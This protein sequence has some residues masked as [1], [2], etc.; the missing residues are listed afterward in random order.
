M[1]AT[2]L[3]TVVCSGTLSHFSVVTLSP[4][5]N[6]LPSAT[7][8]QHNVVLLTPR[9]SGGVVGLATVLQQQP[10]SQVPIQAYANCAMGLPQVEFSF[11]VEPLTVLYLYMFGVLWCML[12]AF[13][14]HTGYHI[15][16]WG[17]SHWGLHDCKLLE[18]THGRHMYNLVMVI[19]PDQVCTEWLPPLF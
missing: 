10:P 13:R 18:L 19:G 1:T 2:P 16:L 6:L 15:H 12:S 7:S 11:R 9:H 4:S 17:L 14:C 5:L 8:G 3:V